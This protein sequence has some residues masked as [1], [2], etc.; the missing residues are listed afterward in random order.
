MTPDLEEREEALERLGSVAR[1]AWPDGA[2]PVAEA[3]KARFEAKIAFR[4]P[5]RPRRALVWASAAAV[6]SCLVAVYV[7]DVRGPGS[8]DY[9]VFPAGGGAGYLTATTTEAFAHFTDGTD[10]RVALGGR[11][12]IVQTDAH[13]AR[14]AVESGKATLHVVHKPG[15][16]WAVDAGP[17]SIAVTGT[18]F[19][20]EWSA[21]DERLVVTLRQGS[22]N[23]RGPFTAEPIALSAGQ[24]LVATVRDAQ[25]R[26]EPIVKPTPPHA[27]VVVPEP[28]LEREPGA[29][30]ANVPAPAPSSPPV[31]TFEQRVRAGDYA[32][33]IRDAKGRG[34]D[35][36]YREGSLADL[37][38]LADAAR[39][40]GEGGIA[41]QS[42]SALERR[43]PASPD[44]K[45]AAFLRGRLAEGRGARSEAIALYDRYLSSSPRGPF[46]AEALGRKMLAVKAESGADAA[47]P[48]AREYLVRFPKGAH[49]ESARK[50]VERD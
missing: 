24:R 39:Y 33:V 18:E 6:L 44:A 2:S 50:L 23:V 10:V 34:L 19:D 32:S 27:A 11:A 3:E 21:A 29:T 47:R 45:A 16:R 17:F 31:S 4:R 48:I 46:V 20:A 41:E 14:V 12:R 22:V 40:T 13:G 35:S 26:I 28:A 49:A 8:L 5:A 38:A 25:L 1:K 30:V 15:A 43:F 9:D 37:S 42:L 36:L 7:L